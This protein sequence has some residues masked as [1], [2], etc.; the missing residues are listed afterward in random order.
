[1]VLKLHGIHM[2]EAR[3]L[4]SIIHKNVLFVDQKS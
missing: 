1:M 4:P 2:N 3:P